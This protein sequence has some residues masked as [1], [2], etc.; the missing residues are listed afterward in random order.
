M[1][2]LNLGIDFKG[3]SIL[4]VKMESAVTS[5]EIRST[6]K[7]LEFDKVDVQ[8]SGNQFY[9]RTEELS[10]EENTEL[11]V[12]LQEKFGN[13]E[14]LSAESVGATIG[15]ELTRNAILSILL[16]TV[17]ML[18]YISVRFEWSFGV[19][20]IVPIIHN[21]LIVL[22]AFSIFQWEVTSAFIAAILTVVGYSING[23]G[24][25]CV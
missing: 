15:N 24:K 16:A 19:A 3:G 9:I 5:A 2:G 25:T 13:V 6:M 22:G 12:S 4:H 1:Q 21:V 18:L 17:L 20:A 23:S 10:Q 7:D 8:K 14:F 11:L